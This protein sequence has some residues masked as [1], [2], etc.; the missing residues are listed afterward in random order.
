MKILA[1][2]LAVV[3]ILALVAGF[4]YYAEAAR[5]L[6]SFFPGSLPSDSKLHFHRKTRGA[7]GVIVGV[8]LLAAAGGLAFTA[9]RDRTKSGQDY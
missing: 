8:L 6:P 7:A 1:A 9:R 5:D 3:G 4:I 2:L